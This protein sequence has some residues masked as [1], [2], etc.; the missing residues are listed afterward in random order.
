LLAWTAFF[1]VGAEAVKRVG[2]E[3]RAATLIGLTELL[4]AVAT[5]VAFGVAASAKNSDFKQR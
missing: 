2:F 5:G 1:I 3:G 4:L